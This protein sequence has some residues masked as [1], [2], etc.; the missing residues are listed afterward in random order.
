MSAKVHLLQDVCMRGG[1]GGI[2]C[3][4]PA[5]LLV[6]NLKIFHNPVSKR[7]EYVLYHFI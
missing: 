5:Q 1:T 3:R 6:Q 4:F 2:V 7:Q